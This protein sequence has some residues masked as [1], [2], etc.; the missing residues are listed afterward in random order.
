VELDAL[1]LLGDLGEL[2]REVPGDRL[3]FTIGVGREE[4]VVR[5]LRGAL[6]L[7]EDFLFS[8]NDFIGFLEAVFDVDA[9][10]LREILDVPLRGQDLVTGSEVLLDRLR[11]GGRFD[12]DERFPHTSSEAQT[13]YGRRRRAG[14]SVIFRSY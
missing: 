4:H 5:V 7:G 3:P 6:Q 11:F 10:L 12:D 13:V 8:R 1:G 14:G 2:L 9:E